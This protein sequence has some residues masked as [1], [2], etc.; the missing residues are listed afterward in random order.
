MPTAPFGD[1]YAEAAFASLGSVSVTVG[2]VTANGLFR[3]N[4]TTLSV[5]D[6][7][8]P[9][10]AL[11]DSVLVRTLA[12]ASVVLAQGVAALV[13]GVAWTITNAQ[14]EGSGLFTRI[15]LATP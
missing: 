6:P 7:G 14:P 3:K 5:Q 13:D 12:F 11:Q 1:A 15:Y 8:G 10:T 9:L 4:G 2:G